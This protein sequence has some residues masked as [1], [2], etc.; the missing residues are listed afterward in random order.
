M[1]I[2]TIIILLI[3]LMIIIVIINL[4]YFNKFNLILVDYKIEANFASF[5]NTLS[6]SFKKLFILIFY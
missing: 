5:L 3:G 4:N 2:I 1:T 6:N